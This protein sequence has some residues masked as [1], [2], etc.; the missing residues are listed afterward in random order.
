MNNCGSSAWLVPTN[1]ELDTRDLEVRD[2]SATNISCSNLS[3]QGNPISDVF[4]NVTAS[5]GLTAFTGDVTADNVYATDEV[6]AANMTCGFLTTGVIT[7][8]SLTA[9]G[10]ITSSAAVSGAT[11]VASGNI[12]QS[13]G[14]AALKA[15][16]AT[17]ISN[18]GTLTQ[19][20]A[21]TLTSTLNVSGTLTCA[22][23]TQSSGTAT[24][25]TVTTSSL[26]CTGSFSA[27]TFNPSNISNSGT[28]TQTGAATFST[29]ITQ[30]AGTAALKAVTADSVSITGSL[31]AGSFSPN[32]ISNTGTL[33]QTGAAT[34]ATN[35][36]QT[37]GTATLEA[38]VC[39]SISGPSSINCIY[40]I[41]RYALS[42][43][44]TTTTTSYETVKGMTGTNYGSMATKLSY[45]STTGVWTNTSG[46]SVLFKIS[47]SLQFTSLAKGFRR[48]SRIRSTSDTDV[49]GEL[50][51]RNVYSTLDPTDPNVEM[52][53]ATTD[54]LLVASNGTFTLQFG[55]QDATG[56]VLG[57]DSY[58]VIECLA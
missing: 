8:S 33:T 17:S 27:G 26:N 54:V 50:Y 2:L 42:A 23:I 30:S 45:N 31:S 13:A 35:I 58:A 46:K 22:N 18:T 20:G 56:V 32:S 7:S 21:A 5:S 29:N 52:F 25:N 55:G 36:T 38:L 51:F 15:V 40:P 53:L 4:E 43:A 12:T 24:L 28:L 47:Y 34:F 48:F 14:T 57:T 3:V 6:T 9:T 16:T 11:L 19:S 10:G 37:S 49:Y 1:V 39:D 41:A 44:L